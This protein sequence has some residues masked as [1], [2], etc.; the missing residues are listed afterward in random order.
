MK[1]KIS[2]FAAVFCYFLGNSQMVVKKYDGTVIN[3]GDVFTYNTIDEDPA[4]LKF[5]VHNTSTTESIL[6]KIECTSISNSDGNL[7]EFCFGGNCFY[8][9]FK[10]LMNPI[11]GPGYMIGPGSNSGDFDHFW[12]KKAESTTGDYPM[13]YQFKIFM[14]DPLGNET[15]DPVNITYRY[16]GALAVNDVN[17]QNIATIK[18]TVVND[19]LTLESK[20]DTIIQIVDISGKVLHTSKI[21]KGNNEIN[22]R[23]LTPGMYIVNIAN[24]TGKMISS[25][26]I[27]K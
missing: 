20:I 24:A 13:D 12:N 26:I 7:F 3:D 4:S 14:V 5:R 15:G 25:K 8:S 18:N 27:K 19:V 22:L 1:K 6:A 2:L 16:A 17:H 10:G 9:V 23:N 21:V 11:D